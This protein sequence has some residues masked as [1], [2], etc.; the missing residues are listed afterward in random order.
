M[1]KVLT[2]YKLCPDNRLTVAGFNYSEEFV[3]SSYGLKGTSNKEFNRL[4]Y[5]LF[6]KEDIFILELG[7]GDGNFI[8]DCVEDAKNA[9]GLDGFWILDKFKPGRW[10]LLPNNLFSCDVCRLFTMLFCGVA[11][12]FDLITSFEFMEHLF[13]EDVDGTIM[14]IADHLKDTGYYICS[15]STR[16]CDGHFCI[17]DREWWLAKFEKYNLIETQEFYSKFDNKYL[18]NLSDSMYFILKN[19]Q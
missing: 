14:N 18:R 2:D 1:F 11:V 12:K 19:K 3:R 8:N 17:R 6:D 5:S 10:A 15:I 9:V 13:E 4:A 7:S 16:N